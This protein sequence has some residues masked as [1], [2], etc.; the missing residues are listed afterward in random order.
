MRL[1]MASALLVRA[2]GIEK[3]TELAMGDAITKWNDPEYGF[4][5]A[6]EKF[7][8][9]VDAEAFPPGTVGLSATE[10]DQMFA[11]GEAAYVL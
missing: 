6:M 4:P 9:L 1:W 8:E 5:Q 7:K 3:A 10:A 2:I 11:R